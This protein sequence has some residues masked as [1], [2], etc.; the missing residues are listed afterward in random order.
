M[1]QD[2]LQ[3]VLDSALVDMPPE[4]K[5]SFVTGEIDEDTSGAEEL[6]IDVYFDDGVTDSEIKSIPI[7]SIKET[8]MKH[9]VDAGFKQFPYFKFSRRE[10]LDSEGSSGA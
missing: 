2:P 6:F 10:D 7:H 8:V 1:S 5:V 4:W 9:L 3:E